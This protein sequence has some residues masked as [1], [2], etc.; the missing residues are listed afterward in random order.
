MG[1]WALLLIDI[2]R[3][4]YDEV[5]DH[6]PAYGEQVAR[7]LSFARLARWPLIIHVRAEFSPDQSDWMLRYWQKGTIPCLAGTPGAQVTDFARPHPGET[8]LV[9][10]RFSAFCRTSL[11]SLLRARGVETVV[12]AGLVTSVCVGLSAA[13][14]YQRDFATL[15]VRDAVADEPNLH[16]RALAQ[17][18]GFIADVVTLDDL[19]AHAEKWR[20]QDRLRAAGAPYDFAR[21]RRK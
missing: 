13:D 4:F 8:T 19:L 6:F 20:A 7:L 11:E 15:L 2:Q 21:F 10:K 14:A 5:S 18:D 12:M 1:E 9:K 17:L 3:D 16:E